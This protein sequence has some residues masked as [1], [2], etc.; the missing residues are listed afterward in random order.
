MAFDW[1]TLDSDIIE[2]LRGSKEEMHNRAASHLG[3]EPEELSYL[4]TEPAHHDYDWC[5]IQI[6]NKVTNVNT[7]TGILR[8]KPV[9]FANEW[10]YGTIWIRT[11]DI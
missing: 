3:V 7:G 9:F 11:S 6:Q 5:H 2:S 10:G 1:Q 8:G 4:D